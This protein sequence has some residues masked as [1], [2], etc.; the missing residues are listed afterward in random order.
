MEDKPNTI[1]VAA[2]VADTKAVT[3][4][5]EN[6]TQMIIK[7]SDHRLQPLL[8]VI[9]PITEKGEIAVIE[10]DDFSVYAAFEEKT[11]GATRFFKVAKSKIAGWFGRGEE[12]QPAK[13]KNRTTLPLDVGQQLVDAVNGINQERET[14][15]VPEALAGNTVEHVMEHGTPVD[16]SDSHGEDE[17]IVAVVGK[18]GNQK[19]ITGAENLKPLISHAIRTNKPEAVQNFLN[20]CAAFIDKR[21]H[22]V[23]DLMRFLEKGDLPLTEDGSIIAYKMLNWSDKAKGIMQDCHTGNIKQEVG[24]Y[25]CI[26][27]KLVDLVRRNECSNGLHI[28]RRG[29]LSGFSGNVCVLCKIDPEDVMVVPH[30]DPNKVRVKGYHI[31]GILSEEATRHLKANKPMTGEEDALRMVYD[32]IRGNHVGRLR[33]VKAH[34]QRGGDVRVRKLRGVEQ[35]TPDVDVTAAEL[36]KA[37]A[38]DTEEIVG[39]GVSPREINR[40]LAEQHEQN[41]KK[42]PETVDNPPTPEGEKVIAQALAEA[43]KKASGLDD[44]LLDWK[45]APDGQPK[46]DAAKALVAFKKAKK[47]AWDK[48]GITDQ[49]TVDAILKDAQTEVTV[50]TE[51]KPATDKRPAV[52]VTTKTTTTPAPKPAKAKP[53]AKAAPAAK[54]PA[55][56]PEPVKAVPPPSVGTGKLTKAEEARKLFKANDMKALVAFKKA[57]KKSWTVLGFSD[58]EIKKIEAQ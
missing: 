32:A 50:K 31:L 20:R 47:K 24:D 25:V 46:V 45:T 51:V 48:I 42:E 21:G 22:S 13:P 33:E 58:A 2:A 17:T 29:Y 36:A 34:A 54:K 18:P 23:E 10:L 16:A 43:P 8:D 4:Y 19:V 14:V 26:D 15:T 7:Q 56:A 41:Q 39:E 9:I 1:R 27:E 11:G 57:A 37:A 40:R 6:G 12:T 52:K 35:A 49:K 53:P 3:L 55:K 5:L 44:L 30:G 28:A 38:I